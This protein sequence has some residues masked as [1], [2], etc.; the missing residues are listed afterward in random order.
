MTRD[1]PLALPLGQHTLMSINRTYILY[2]D[3]LL[4]AGLKQPD[5]HLL[6][7]LL[8]V[9]RLHYFGVWVIIFVAH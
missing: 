7:K 5:V 9:S 6:C 4:G 2:V 3:V 8:C 1:L